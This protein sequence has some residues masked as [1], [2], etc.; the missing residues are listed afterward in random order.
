MSVGEVFARV[1]RFH[2]T[3]GRNRNGSI[4]D[5]LWTYLYPD[6]TPEEFVRPETDEEMVD[7]VEEFESEEGSTLP[8]D[9]DDSFPLSPSA[10]AEIEALEKAE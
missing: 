2:T 9:M 10:L 7:E 1:V 6:E 8:M 4:F 3:L 5:Y